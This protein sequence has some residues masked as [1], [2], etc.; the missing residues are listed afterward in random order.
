[1][2]TIDDLRFFAK[3]ASADSLV[4]VARKLDVTPSAVTQRLKQLEE[5]A[6]VRLI[7]R[8]ARRLSL[9]SE[10]E[11][12]AAR[13]H[14][15][16]NDIDDLVDDLAARRDEVTGQLRIM[17]PLTF[18]R[19]HIAPAVARFRQYYPE[20]K[21]DLFLSDKPI[22]TSAENF[23]VTVHIGE[24]PNSSLLMQRLAPN[25]RYM[26]ASPDYLARQ[27]QPNTPDD[28]RRHDC[29]AVRENNEDVTMW[30]LTKNGKTAHIR[31]TPT[32][33]SNEGEVARNWAIAGHGIIVR[34]EWN[35]AKALSSGQLVRVLPEFTLPDADVV[36]LLGHRHGRT[37]RVSAF[38]MLLRDE[39]TPTP[40]RKPLA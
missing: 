2:V 37:A 25:R 18:G 16:V 3:L 27:G 19:H 8:T 28:L 9:T 13:G 5:R 39:L 15:I 24:L 29:I 22:V 23:D 12:V 4:E 21:I 14:N 11:L 40:W 32:L 26:C 30:R 17:A 6:G 36:A 20:V 1:M 7:D 35:V 38:L 31:M 33:A 34:S 10:G